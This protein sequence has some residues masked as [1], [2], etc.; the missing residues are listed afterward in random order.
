MQGQ[1]TAFVIHPLLRAQHTTRASRLP[2]AVG[3]GYMI[4]GTVYRVYAP[5]GRLGQ[6]LVDLILL[7][8]A[9]PAQR[10][11]LR[12]MIGEPIKRLAY[13]IGEPI[14]MTGKRALRKA[15]CGALH[16]E[17]IGPKAL[18]PTVVPGGQRHGGA[19]RHLYF[20]ELSGDGLGAR[21]SPEVCTNVHIPTSAALPGER[22]VRE[23]TQFYDTSN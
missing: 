20:F 3:I 11:I 9:P 8:C 17:A 18:Y 7:V 5:A 2:F 14:K 22:Q 15:L 6:Q 1:H 13:L 4:Y 12:E 21:V 16:S 23:S 19:G 10:D